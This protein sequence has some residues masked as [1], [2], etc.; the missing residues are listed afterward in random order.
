LRRNSRRAR[1]CC[2]AAAFGEIARHKVHAL[3]AYHGEVTGRV[4]ANL[5]EAMAGWK[6]NLA[7]VT[8]EFEGWQADAMME[9]MGAVSLHG[10]GHLAGFLFRAQASVERSVRAFVDRLAREIERALGIHFE[11]ARFDPQVEEPAHPVPRGGPV[12]R[13]RGRLD[14]RSFPGRDGVSRV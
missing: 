3:H 2:D 9:E 14:R 12:G 13:R 7:R 11:G 10:E 1:S 6:G 4:T 8:R 5:R